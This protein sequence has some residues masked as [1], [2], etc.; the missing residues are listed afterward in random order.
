MDSVAWSIENNQPMVTGGDE[1]LKDMIVVTGA[2][3][4]LA[5]GKKVTLG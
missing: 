5:S 1:G 4:A 2:F 3:E